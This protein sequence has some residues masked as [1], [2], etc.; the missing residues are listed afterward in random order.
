ML[1]DHLDSGS[2]S[3]KCSEALSRSPGKTASSRSHGAD[4]RGYQGTLREI[5]TKIESSVQLVADTLVDVSHEAPSSDRT[6]SV[7]GSRRP[8]CRGWLYLHL[9][10]LLHIIWSETRILPQRIRNRYSRKGSRLDVGYLYLRATDGRSVR[11]IRA[12]GRIDCIERLVP[13]VLGPRR[14]T[15]VLRLMLGT[16]EWNGL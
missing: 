6:E 5:K 11:N 15:G 3:I 1:W 13:I 4:S 12:H 2:R 7:I 9:P 10:P 8:P 14:K 16:R